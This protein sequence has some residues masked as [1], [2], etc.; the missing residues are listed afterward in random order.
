MT[1]P[2]QLEKEEKT[3]T[4]EDEYAYEDWCAD[5]NE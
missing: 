4:K 1:T 3:I 5:N 2:E